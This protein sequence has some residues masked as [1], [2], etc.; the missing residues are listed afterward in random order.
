MQSSEIRLSIADSFSNPMLIKLK[1]STI[2][3]ILVY[4][5]VFITT[6]GLEHAGDFTLVYFGI[7]VLC[8]LGL[9]HYQICRAEKK[10]EEERL[11]SF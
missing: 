5:Y 7:F 2:Q 1:M 9:T 11:N 3:I 6:Y 8:A 10:K 4:L